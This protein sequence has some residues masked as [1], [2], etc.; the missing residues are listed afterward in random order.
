MYKAMYVWVLSE[1]EDVGVAYRSALRW[2]CNVENPIMTPPFLKKNMFYHPFMLN[3][4]GWFIEFTTSAVVFPI[5]VWPPTASCVRAGRPNVGCAR[6]SSFT[7]KQP[8]FAD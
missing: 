2:E 8:L 3:I 6:A 5:H 1:T 7:C 4:W